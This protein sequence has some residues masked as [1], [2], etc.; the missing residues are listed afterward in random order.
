M[1]EMQFCYFITNAHELL[2]K[3]FAFF[4]E[5]F[6]GRKVSEA[7]RRFLLWKKSRKHLEEKKQVH[8]LSANDHLLFNRYDTELCP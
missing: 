3:N 7:T 8:T 6:D 5:M 2:V 1:K 4:V